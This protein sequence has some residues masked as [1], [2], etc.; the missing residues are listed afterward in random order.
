MFSNQVIVLVETISDDSICVLLDH[1]EILFVLPFNSKSEFALKFPKE[2]RSEET[3]IDAVLA[4]TCMSWAVLV[5][6]RGNG[7]E[8]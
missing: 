7:R 1:S 3:L 2:F 8:G 4:P 5:K 6:R